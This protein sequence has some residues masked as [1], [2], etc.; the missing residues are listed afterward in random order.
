MTVVLKPYHL[1]GGSGTS[2]STPTGTTH[3][4]PH[5]Y[6]THVPLLVMGPGIEPGIRREQ[7]SSLGALQRPILA[8]GLGID[9][10][11]SATCPVPTRLFR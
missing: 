7:V 6:D 4:S 3:G 2:K 10:P 8:H 1:F 5:S 11:E 9:A